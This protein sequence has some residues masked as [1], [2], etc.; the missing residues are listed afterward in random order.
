MVMDSQLPERKRK[1]KSILVSQPEPQVGSNPYLVLAEKHKLKL[2]FRPFI[3]VVGVNA[4][5]FR[6][7]KIALAEFKS[8]IFTSRNAIDHFFRMCEEMRVAINPEWKYFCTSEAVA[9][10]LQKFVPYR[11]R[12]IYPAK[13]ALTDLIPT[14][15]KQRGE[16]FLMPTSD[17]LNPEVPAALAAANIKWT[18]AVMYQTVA[19]SLSDLSE[20]KYDMLVFFSP[21]GIKSLFKNFP[22]FVQ[23]ATRIAA[24][25]SSSHLAAKEHNLIVDVPVPSPKFA[26]M[27]QALE[28]YV[29]EVNK[30][31]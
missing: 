17:V 1:V 8:F 9:F 31:K 19:A 5:E 23:D 12:K 21:E 20:V 15:K 7:D 6:K 29:D 24:F 16:H 4:A 13:S 27:A 30:G 11:K 25:G 10:Y 22:D 26:S 3:E 14:L 18:R 28:A 2:D